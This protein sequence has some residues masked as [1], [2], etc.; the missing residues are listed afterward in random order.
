[1]NRYIC[2]HGHFYQPPRENPWLEAIELQDSAY[3]YND[4]NE[5]IADESYGPNAE[6]RILD[7]Y[8]HIVDIV[9]NYE[10]ISFN[11]GPT[12]LSWMQINDPQTYQKILDADKKSIEKFNGHGSAI[13]QAFNHIILPLANTLDKRTQ[14]RWGIEDFRLRFGRYPEGMWLAET[15]VDYESLEILVEHGIK[16]TILS[17]YQAHQTK[18]ILDVEWQ[19]VDGG[20]IDPK[21][22]YTCYLPNGTSI[23]IFF[24]DGPISQDIAFGQLLKDGAGFAQRL[25]S[26]FSEEDENPQL[27]HI[28]N[29]GETYGHHQ[30]FGNMALAYLIDHIQKNDLAHVTIYGEYL[31]KFPPTHEVRIHENSS[32]SCSHGVERWKDDCGC[33][34]GMRPDWNQ[35]WRKPLREAMDW[36]RDQLI[37]IYQEKAGA[38][39][40]DVWAARDDYIVVVSD[41]STKNVDSFLER[42][43]R[44]SLSS[45]E[46]IDILKL[47]EMQRHAMLMYTSCG[48]FFDDISGIENVQIMQY[49]ARAMQLA[50]D[51]SG[52]DFEGK[53]IKILE[54]AKSN[55]L[56]TRTG[57]QVY[58]RYVK[59]SKIDLL[60]VGAHFAISSLFEDYPKE[61][62]IYS[63]NVQCEKYE[64]LDSLGSTLILGQV[65]VQ[66]KITRKKEK[67]TFALIY[68]GNHIVSVGVKP[69]E[70]DE[71]FQKNLRDIKKSY[72]QGDMDEVSHLIDTYFSQ[73]RY[74]L[75]DLFKN[76]QGK[77]LDRICQETLVDIEGN[78]RDIYDQYFPLLKI[79]K[80]IR[81]PLPKSLNM[82]V[83]FILNRELMTLL[84]SEGLD[85]D[86]LERLAREIK[87]W[88]FMRDKDS[89]IRVAEKKIF[90]LLQE[91]DRNPQDIQLL[92]SIASG[93][94]I[95]KALY[96]NL[97]LW[98]SQDL[99]FKIFKKHRSGF[100]NKEND[101]KTKEWVK[102][103]D[104][105]GRYLE[106]QCA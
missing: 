70:G 96:L 49:A 66:S 11:F 97:N 44:K 37:V 22:P 14:I 47:M 102:A 64:R 7:E 42:H 36:L 78:F 30:K 10:S 32:W 65:L 87:R 83:E 26:A 100:E 72:Q 35:K 33:C 23:A 19:N 61:L 20:C 18:A 8:Q 63:Y 38:Y 24:Y 56:E 41:R 93:L 71:L 28:S 104:R 60:H 79:Q 84:E 105:L 48:W 94:R 31:E 81:V 95:L 39:L 15:A 54:K 50:K 43:S 55:V 85:L 16:F 21:M 77:A 91:L 46:K 62:D 34:S 25:L 101:V 69:F 75:W 6:T 3:P 89:V 17:P 80:D 4:W 9:N 98:K 45:Q 92:Q 103:F 13:A 106:I 86:Q 73:N 27:V 51:V 88:A 40:K 29:D 5:R 74:S 59:Q 12:L 53:Y 67:M 82:V 76:E 1:M 99:Y 90:L 52:Q 57:K 68:K 58:Y 2:I